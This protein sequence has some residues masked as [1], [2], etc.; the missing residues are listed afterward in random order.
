M[1]LLLAASC[2]RGTP[3][4]E[5]AAKTEQHHAGISVGSEERAHESTPHLHSSNV[6]EDHFREA[7]VERCLSDL[8]SLAR[9]PVIIEAVLEANRTNDQTPEQVLAKD[10]AWRKSP[11]ANSPLLEPF[12]SNACAQFLKAR[13]KEHPEYLELFV[14]D[15]KGC[16]VGESNRTSDYWQGDEDKWV[17]SFNAGVGKVFVDA[18]AYDES[19]QSYV[20]QISLPVFD[21]A[22]ATIGAMTVSVQA[23]DS[24]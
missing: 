8:Q 19:T 20:V 7:L 16:I 24:K 6:K 1:L 5:T 4:S 13:Q 12:L 10:A 9:D 18:V 17:Q 14:M 11:T 2:A 3:E 23:E 22:G 15:A 21:T